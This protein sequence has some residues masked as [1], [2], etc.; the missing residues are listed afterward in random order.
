MTHLS[1]RMF[2]L[3]ENDVRGNGEKAKM[4]WGITM[5]TTLNHRSNNNLKIL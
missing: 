5:P 2:N 3:V 1:S 4:G